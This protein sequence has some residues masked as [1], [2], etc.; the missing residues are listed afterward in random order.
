MKHFLLLLIS[1]VAGYAFWSF[2]DKKERLQASKLI[3][4]HT[5]RLGAFILLLLFLLLAA[6]QLVSTKII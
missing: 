6:T 3:T 2:A 1:V 4:R 5:L